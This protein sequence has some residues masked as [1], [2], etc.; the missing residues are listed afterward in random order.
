MSI[1]FTSSLIDAMDV[2]YTKGDFVRTL[3]FFAPGDG[4]AAVYRVD[5]NT[6]TPIT[7]KAIQYTGLTLYCSGGKFHLAPDA[8]HPTRPVFEF[9]LQGNTV[10]AEQFG[11]MP[12]DTSLAAANTACI[13]N[14]VD[15]ATSRGAK[16]EFAAKGKYYFGGYYHP[17]DWNKN[18]YGIVLKDNIL[19]DG[20]GAV[21]EFADSDAAFTF[22]YTVKP[23]IARDVILRN[24]TCIGRRTNNGGIGDEFLYANIDGF[25]MQNVTAKNFGY[26]L[27][28][29]TRKIIADYELPEIINKNWLIEDC[30]INTVMGLQVSEIDGLTIKNTVNTSLYP[31]ADESTLYPG[32][33]GTHNIYM[34]SNCINVRLNNVTMGNVTGNAIHKSYAINQE[35]DN[36]TE[37]E[38]SY[39]RFDKS[40]NH[41]YTDISVYKCNAPLAIGFASENVMCDNIF[42][43]YLR[44]EVYLSAVSNCII[45]NS[46]LVANR[47]PIGNNNPNKGLYVRSACSCWF[48]N[49]YLY[50]NGRQRVGAYDTEDAHYH[51]MNI[52][53]PQNTLA[54]VDDKK[55]RRIYI[56]EDFDVPNH[57]FKFTG[58]KMESTYSETDYYFYEVINKH[59][60]SPAKAQFGEFLDN[61]SYSYNA[62]SENYRIMAINDLFGGITYRNCYMKNLA[63]TEKI[64][65]P[66]FGHHCNLQASSG[67]LKD[68]FCKYNPNV[69]CSLLKAN[70]KYPWLHFENNIYDNFSIYHSSNSWQYYF[71]SFKAGAAQN[72]LTHSQVANLI[73]AYSSNCFNFIN[74]TFEEIN[75]LSSS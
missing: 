54:N 16:L 64:V 70:K 14:A 36:D 5:S 55:H 75:D 49:S 31:D 11:V 37:E 38:K 39:Y 18:E 69:V 13:N 28:T 30:T 46:T 17:T 26:G 40:K 25:V 19:L 60:S 51:K 33:R 34:E 3:G 27:R 45:A 24:I 10:Y 8:T 61:C 1:N 58:C 56:G 43:T 23:N 4:G 29:V 62:T 63:Q 6:S 22:F 15:Y 35:H 73:G 66:P 53:T 32:G 47:P 50:T 42:A 41:F 9:V 48:Q 21:L 52:K 74:N 57:W 68:Y 72:R 71:K 44:Y 67:D 2:S 59:F 7:D 20:N 65:Q 12:K